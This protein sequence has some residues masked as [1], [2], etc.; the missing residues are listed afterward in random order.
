M[1][2]PD[3]R[4][5]IEVEW[6][7]ARRPKGPESASASSVKVRSRVRRTLTLVGV[8][9]VWVAAGA[10][11]VLVVLAKAFSAEHQGKWET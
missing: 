9:A 7:E 2:R 1:K 11:S 3:M 4:A 10:L 8:A 6:K 5:R